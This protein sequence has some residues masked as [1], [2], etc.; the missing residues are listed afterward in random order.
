MNTVEK[1]VA[2]DPTPDA[3][4]GRV[5]SSTHSRSKEDIEAG[6]PT[7]DH[8][9]T[10][11]EGPPPLKGLSLL[12]RFLVVWI[13]LA[14]AIGIVLGNTVPS[15]G[16]ALQQGTFVGVSIPIGMFL[17]SYKPQTTY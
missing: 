13:L 3:G 5:H 2:D 1:S 7:Q 15:T 16:P 6:S 8:E 11:N 17:S 10:E 14:M 12:D 9:E 4:L